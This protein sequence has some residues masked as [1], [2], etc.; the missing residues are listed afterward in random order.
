MVTK[1]SYKILVIADTH[2]GHEIGLTP[3]NWDDDSGPPRRKSLYAIRRYTWDWFEKQIHA[4]GPYDATIFNGDAIDGK[5]DKT[6]GTEQLFTDRKDQSDMAIDILKRFPLGKLYMSYGTP[7]HTGKSEDWER[8][9]ARPNRDIG[10]QGAEKLEGEGNLEIAGC[11]INYR[12][13]VGR[14]TIPHGRHTAIAR[15]RL[16]NLLWAE[17][18][19]FPKA[20][21]LIRSHVHYLSYCG[22][23]NWLAFTTPAACAYGT[24]FGARIVT[25]IVDC[26]FIVIEIS[27][28]GEYTWKPI[29]LRFPYHPPEQL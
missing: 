27:S 25:G 18:E 19:E 15:E 23:P 12:H 22:G 26:G 8:D 9:I 4:H 21:I 16:W 24:K 10:W 17:R 14:S 6:G 28:K 3:P 11:I 2:S 5:G 7:Y 29:L 20:N 13:H 1:K